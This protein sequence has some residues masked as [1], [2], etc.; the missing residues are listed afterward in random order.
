MKVALCDGCG[1]RIQS[2]SQLKIIGAY[3]L[4]DECY[5]LYMKIMRDVLCRPGT[6]LWI[7]N[8][9]LVTVQRIN[10]ARGVHDEGLHIQQKG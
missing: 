5:K 9:V 1:S 3:D 8:N 2:N 7:G 4:C 10:D 6:R